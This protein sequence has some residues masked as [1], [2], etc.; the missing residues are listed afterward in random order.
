VKRD[1]RMPAKLSGYRAS[2]FLL[3]IC[4]A[5]P[6]AFVAP[7]Y[8]CKHALLLNTI[9]GSAATNTFEQHKSSTKNS[10]G[11]VFVRIYFFHRQQVCGKLS[12]RRLKE[13]LEKVS[14]KG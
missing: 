10:G 2:S 12:S 8:A 5:V 7:R 11:S 1:S 6:L 4:A 14:G 3:A 13:L 9:L